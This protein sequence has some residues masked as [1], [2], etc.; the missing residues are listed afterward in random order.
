[1][2]KFEYARLAFNIRLWKWLDRDINHLWERLAKPQ[3]PFIEM[4]R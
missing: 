4:V 3:Y 1:V 2:R